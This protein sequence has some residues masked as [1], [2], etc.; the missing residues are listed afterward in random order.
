[1]LVALAFAASAFAAP[2]QIAVDL[3][4]AGRHLVHTRMTI[5]ASPGAMTLRYPKWLPGEHG[6]TGPIKN[7]AGLVMTASGKTLDWTRDPREMY[8]FRVDVPAGAQSLEVAFDL[9]SSSDAP[10]FT[11]GA[12]T[13]PKLALLSW[14]QVL[15][16]PDG[17]KGDGIEYEARITLPPRWSFATALPL[18]AKEGSG[19]AFRPVTLTRL[20][21]SPVLAGEHLKTIVLDERADGGRVVLDMAADNPE[22]LAI[23]PEMEAAYKGLVAEA[24]ALFGARH[25]VSYHF[26]LTI[27]DQVAHFGLEHHE[28]SDNRVRERAFLD[29][30]VRKT[31]VGL[32]SHEYVHSWNGK[33]RRPADLNPDDFGSPVDSSLLWV[34]EGLTQYLGWVLAGRSGLRT[35]EASLDDLAL[36]SAQLDHRAGRRWRALEDTAV[37]AQLLF[38]TPDAW[39]SWRRQVDFYDEGTLIW[40]EADVMIRRLTKGAKSLD[41]FCRR[42]HGGRGGGPEV[43]TYRFEDVAQALNAVAPHDW[44]GFLRDRV[45]RR[46]AGAPLGG[47]EQGGWRIGYQPTRTALQASLEE[48]YETSDLRYSIGVQLKKDGTVVD[49]VPESLGWKVGLGPGMKV[50]AVN[51]LKFSPSRLRDA[52]RGGGRVRLIVENGE[53]FSISEL[54]V[55]GGERYPRLTR[56]TGEDLLGAILAPKSGRAYKKD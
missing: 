31:M 41:D 9:L 3:T 47:I 45:R 18:R 27:S 13:T 48:V 50:V 30:D 25:F 35:A 14:N 17:T 51:E 22:A 15:L 33:Y 38:E 2:V 37:A 6:P 26:L 12:S 54:P 42:F 4:D 46:G 34:Y 36:A 49:V 5:P 55:E 11:S 16:Y 56:G 8:A 44:A 53:S 1:M 28:S 19:A 7:I 43:K 40:L 21:D 24:D 29:P 52:V 23:P 20:V 39:G 32:L 10:G